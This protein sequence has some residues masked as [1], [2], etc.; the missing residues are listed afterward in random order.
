MNAF[1]YFHSEPVMVLRNRKV[2]LR[3]AALGFTVAVVIGVACGPA[4]AVGA[5]VSP[6]V[7]LPL[8][9]GFFDG[10]TALYITPEVGVGS[11]APVS[12][13]DTLWAILPANMP[14]LPLL[15]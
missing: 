13:I 14:R 8:Q 11:N 1:P 15:T 3:A 9:V 2:S 4:I 5:T 6:R 10:E 12:V 7:S